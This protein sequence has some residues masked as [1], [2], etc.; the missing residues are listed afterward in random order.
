M[1]D[2]FVIIVLGEDY[3]RFNEI[4]KKIDEELSYSLIKFEGKK[5][6]FSIANGYSKYEKGLAYKDAFQK[7]DSSMYINKK[8][9]KEKYKMTGR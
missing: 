4:M 6:I 2:F 3:Q 7:A 8:D 5:L 9:L 1:G